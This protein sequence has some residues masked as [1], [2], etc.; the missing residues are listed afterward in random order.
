MQVCVLSTQWG[1][2]NWNIWSRERFIAGLSKELGGS[3]PKTPE[4]LKVFQQS[5]F[6]DKVREW[7]G[8]VYSYSCPLSKESGHGVPVNL[9]RDK[10]YSLFCNFLAL[11]EWTLRGQSLQNKI[12]CLFQVYRKHSF[13]KGAGPEWLITGNGIDLIWSQICFF[14]LSYHDSFSF[15]CVLVLVFALFSGS[16]YNFLLCSLFWNFY[17]SH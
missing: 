6:K 4:L 13:T 8:L 17:F 2:T 10:C 5:T 3:F 11:Y 12:S 14:L 16:F 9:Q 7:S 15:G 1:Q